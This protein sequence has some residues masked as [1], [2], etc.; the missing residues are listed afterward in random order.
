[1]TDKY[2]INKKTMYDLEIAD[3]LTNTNMTFCHSI[4]MLISE[5]HLKVER[6]RIVAI[7]MIDLENNYNKIFNELVEYKKRYGELKP[8]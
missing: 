2:I 4:G 3:L 8:L 7:A 5:K 1:V 6:Y